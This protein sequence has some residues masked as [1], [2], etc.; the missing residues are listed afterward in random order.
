MFT[1]QVLLEWLC[2]RVDMSQL[3]TTPT[4]LSSSHQLPYD[5]VLDWISVLMDVHFTELALQP[6][7]RHLLSKLHGTIF[8]QVYM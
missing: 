3:L 6:Q 5:C 2:H 1:L 8:K 7:A 4:H